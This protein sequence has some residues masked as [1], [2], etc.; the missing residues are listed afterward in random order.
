MN[1]P[2]FFSPSRRPAFTLVE[3]LVVLGVISILI[4]ILLPVLSS[5]RSEAKRVQCRSHLRSLHVGF[6]L[7]AADYDGW[8]PDEESAYTWDALIQ[9]YI[10][11]EREY[12][13]ACPEDDDG[14]YED[15][16]TSYE[17]RDWFA[18][19]LDFPERSLANKRLEEASPDIALIFDGLPDWH[20]PNTRNA[21]AVDGSAKTWDEDEFQ[22]NLEQM[23]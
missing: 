9:P 6:E 13:W 1:T 12:V 15:Y 19:D 22:A 5:G 23:P 4:L 11:E 3:V 10:A 16:A 21:S 7:Y 8:V 17:I 18:V 2:V 14:F 20:A